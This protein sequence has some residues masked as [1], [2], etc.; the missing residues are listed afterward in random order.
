MLSYVWFW[1]FRH[2]VNE[3]YPVLGYYAAI[4][5]SILAKFQEKLWSRPLKFE[6]IGCPEISVRN[7]Q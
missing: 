6:P 1:G 4:Y 5:S 3:N 2:E 7:Y